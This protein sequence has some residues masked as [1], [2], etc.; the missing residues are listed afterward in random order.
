MN[1]IDNQNIKLPI[2]NIQNHS[3]MNIEIK[4]FIHI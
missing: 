1:I 3:K 4:I 2:R